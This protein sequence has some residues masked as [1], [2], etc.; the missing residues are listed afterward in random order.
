M[1]YG[2]GGQKRRR[3]EPKLLTSCCHELSAHK[4]RLLWRNLIVIAK[5]INHIILTTIGKTQ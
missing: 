2:Q 3:E 1:Q 5:G 4:E